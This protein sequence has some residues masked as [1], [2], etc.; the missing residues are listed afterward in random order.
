MLSPSRK[1]TS[2]TKQHQHLVGVTGCGWSPLFCCH[3]EPQK[4]WFCFSGPEESLLRF[5]IIHAHLENPSPIIIQLPSHPQPSPRRGGLHPPNHPIKQTLILVNPHHRKGG[6]PISPTLIVYSSAQ[7]SLGATGKSSSPVVAGI[8][9]GTGTDCP[10]TNN[11]PPV[12]N[13]LINALAPP[14]INNS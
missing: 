4:N 10:P 5:F 7:L 11:I 9:C 1:G 13:E 12:L 2:I 14:S 8:A 3:S 6:H